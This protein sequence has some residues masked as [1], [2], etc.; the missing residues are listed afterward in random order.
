MSFLRGLMSF[1]PAM[2]FAKLMDFAQWCFWLATCLEDVWKCHHLQSVAEKERHHMVHQRQPHVP[3][4]LTTA[5]NPK[6]H[7]LVSKKQCSRII[8]VHGIGF[9]YGW[10]P[11]LLPS[12]RH[13]SRWRMDLFH[14]YGDPWMPVWGS[15]LCPRAGNTSIDISAGQASMGQGQGSEFSRSDLLGEL[16]I[17]KELGV[18]ASSYYSWPF[19][20]PGRLPI[21]RPPKWTD[22][23]Q[24]HG[25]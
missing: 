19:A 11:C 2:M 22:P 15:G 18:V 1:D 17:L 6:I 5:V 24:N 23:I 10:W 9:A 3:W 20:L 14:W 7:C 8:V 21:V 4:I 13:S 25:F 16:P 12:S